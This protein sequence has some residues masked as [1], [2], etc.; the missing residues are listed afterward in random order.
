MKAH[1]VL[2]SIRWERFA[3]ACAIALLTTLGGCAANHVGVT[4]YGGM[5]EVL[6]DGATQARVKLADASRTPHAYG[7]GAL[8]NLE[9]EVTILNGDVW[10]ARKAGADLRMTGPAVVASDQATLLTLTSVD[11]WTDVA[12]PAHLSGLDL[13]AEIERIAQQNGVDTSKPFP[14][15]IEGEITKLEAHVIAGGCPM[16]G[17]A[18]NPEPWRLSI[19]APTKGTLV[20]F[21][22][23]DQAGVMTHHGSRTHMHVIMTLDDRTITA[24]VEE[25]SVAAG[26]VLRLPA[27][28]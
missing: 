8:A 26:S 19:D 12:L 22:A 1:S 10:V 24:H 16:S 14:F 6:R 21:F 18:D 4:Q 20:G 5:R 23:N 7:V 3:A 9:G 2:N 17:A 15:L 28:R 27:P 25:A 11:N 13:E